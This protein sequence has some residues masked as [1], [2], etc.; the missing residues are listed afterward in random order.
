MST[1]PIR[2]TGIARRLDETRPGLVD[3]LIAAVVLVV[4]ATSFVL[5]RSGGLPPVTW[6]S[7]GFAVLAAA[8]LVWRRR[9]PLAVLVVCV[10]A[11]WVDTVLGGIGQPVPWAGLVAGYTVAARAPAWQHW[12]M[13]GLAVILVPTGLLGTEPQLRD[14]L[15]G[16][17][18]YLAMYGWGRLS[19]AH[20]D[21]T[22]ALRDRAV[23]VERAMEAE[24]RQ[25]AGAERAR[26]ARDMHNVLSHTIELVAVQAEAGPATMRSDP[27]RA[28]ASFDA[29]AR[30]ARRSMNQLRRMSGVLAEDAAAGSGHR[31]GAGP[32]DLSELIS[33]VEST[34]SRVEL[35]ESGVPVPVP[36]DVRLTVHR[37]VRAAL[38]EIVNHVDARDATVALDWGTTELTVS[39]TDD[40]GAKRTRP[41]PDSGGRG[42]ALMRKWAAEHGGTVD[43]WP[44]PSGRGFRVVAR[45]PL[46]AGPGVRDGA[47][48]AGRDGD[49]VESPA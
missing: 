10:L 25:A 28:E 13:H 1:I 9:R 22:G 23:A 2:A 11:G 39:I 20:R 15:L 47:P 38:G 21:R 33:H 32:A 31:T 42:V 14:H 44:G 27:A 46:V 17:V 19:A 36:D 16:L 43:T 5:P 48:V 26:I 4:S 24:A 3:T 49:V 7:Y 12:V 29:I 41:R 8:A 35:V 18:G 6:W 37:I 45:F 34:G 40:G 30:T